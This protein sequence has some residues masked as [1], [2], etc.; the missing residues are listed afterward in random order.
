M[1]RI[2]RSGSGFG[3]VDL[4][5]AVQ[6]ELPRLD[7]SDRCKALVGFVLGNYLLRVVLARGATGSFLA[8]LELFC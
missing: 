3:G 5:L 2:G 8:C 7:R 6:P 1:E 4:R